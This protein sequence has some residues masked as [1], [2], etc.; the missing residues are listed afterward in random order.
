[1]VKT[2]QQ[3]FDAISQRSEEHQKAFDYAIKEKLYSQVGSIIRQELDSLIRLSYYEC[4]SESDRQK[5]IKKF[6]AGEK[7]FPNDTTLVNGVDSKGLLNKLPQLGWAKHIYKVGCEFVHLTQLHNWEQ[8]EPQLN[9][10][11][12]E[13]QDI[14]TNVDWWQ[15]EY[16]KTDFVLDINFGFKD[17][18]AAAPGIFNKLRVNLLSMLKRS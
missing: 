17:L 15:K 7:V 11:N 6:F 4:L 8:G 13:R 18:A 14:K 5:I 2:E 16:M 9:F 3:F 10:T 1:M 12:A